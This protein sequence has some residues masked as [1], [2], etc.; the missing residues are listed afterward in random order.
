MPAPIFSLATTGTDPK[1][2]TAQIL[3]DE[4]NRV[5][6][7]TYDQANPEDAAA[8]AL[9]AEKA[10][11]SEANAAASEVSTADN[12]ASSLTYRDQ[13][14]AAAIAA[15]AKLVTSLTTPIPANG[16][17]ELLQTEAGTQ[18]HEVQ[19]GSWAQIGW[20]GVPDFP[21][22]AAMGGASGFIDGQDVFAAGKRF[23]YDADSITMADGEFVVDAVGMGANPATRGRLVSK[24]TDFAAPPDILLDRR[25][26][27]DGTILSSQGARVIARDTVQPLQNAG[28]QFL[29]FIPFN[30]GS[31]L[32]ANGPG[33]VNTISNINAVASD[34]VTYAGEYIKTVFNL[35]GADAYQLLASMYIATPVI[36]NPDGATWQ[37]APALFIQGQPKD[38]L[39]QSGSTSFGLFVFAGHNRIRD[40]LVVGNFDFSND[41][42]T[43]NG[44]TGTDWTLTVRNEGVAQPNMFRVIEPTNSQTGEQADPG[45]PML[46]MQPWN[47]QGAYFEVRT[48]GDILMT[49]MGEGA[50]QDSNK[51]RVT[52]Y[53]LGVDSNGF[54]TETQKTKVG[55]G[56]IGVALSSGATIAPRGP[57]ETILLNG[58][59]NPST[60]TLPNGFDGQEIILKAS[61][62]SSTLVHMVTGAFQFDPDQFPASNTASIS[63]LN[64]ESVHLIFRGSGTNR[65][66]V[67]G[68]T[69]R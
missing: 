28:G 36:N 4:V 11:N 5:I 32:V 45:F 67:V 39:D 44:G 54:L 26:F 1:A 40:H 52:S 51:S 47:G 42:L 33:E 29:E 3:E 62:T 59:G 9:S 30:Q 55:V 41:V 12:T 65:W 37:D 66:V 16:S 61:Q 25:T 19:A 10:A 34:G 35:D 38:P 21:G 58:T 31:N 43:A 68:R 60:Y 22:I 69:K 53:I 6:G 64:F 7:I 24:E 56:N 48:G 14:Q 63:L 17:I 8:A 15:G 20:L 50:W 23:T 18:V 2:T 49:Q 57:V 27:E 46:R 13:A